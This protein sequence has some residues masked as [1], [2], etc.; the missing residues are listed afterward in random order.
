MRVWMV[1]DMGMPAPQLAAGAQKPLAHWFARMA[2][3]SDERVR[4]DV[5]ALPGQFDH[6]DR[7]IAEG[8]IGGDEPNAA[9]F[10]IATTVR[11]FLA[12]DDVRP[13][14]EGRPAAE[15]AMRLL[16]RYP[17]PIPAFLPREWLA[18]AR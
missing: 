4:A 7:L 9:D 16:P 15:L 1:R 14:I 2:G 11:V 17:G 5:A 18:E 10:Q 13:L 3:V 12:Y 6:V 8:V